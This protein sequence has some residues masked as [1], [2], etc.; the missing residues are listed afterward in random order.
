[1]SDQLLSIA[2]K[3]GGT[4]LIIG[5]LD[6]DG[7][8]LYR[9]PEIVYKEYLTEHVGEN[10]TRSDIYR[11]IFDQT[12]TLLRTHKLSAKNV[13]ANQILRIYISFAGPI[14]HVT[15]LVF[16]PK[17]IPCMKEPFNLKQEMYEFAINHQ[18]F[19]NVK[20]V[21]S[22][23]IHDAIASILGETTEQGTIP[24]INN[25]WTFLSGTGVGAG[26]L[27]DGKPFYG[28]KINHML[29]EIGYFLIREVDRYKYIGYEIHGDLSIPIQYPKSI[30][31]RHRFSTADLLTRYASF[32]LE[33]NAGN[34][35]TSTLT[36]YL[37]LTN[38]VT[39]F[40]K[41]I[42]QILTNRLAATDRL[43]I[44]F[45]QMMSEEFSQALSVF[46]AHPKHQNE[47]FIYHTV[48]GGSLGNL[49]QIYSK[50][51][52]DMIKKSMFVTLQKYGF[53]QPKSKQ[54]SEGIVFSQ[55]G[56]ER[57]LY[58]LGKIL[59]DSKS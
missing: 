47:E 15:N 29:G 7:Q 26:F 39:I 53:S 30:V 44:K 55:I 13:I 9:T 35:D 33:N 49:S 48:I 54:I 37:A 6:Q 3:L 5:L 51:F 38:R 36:K 24:G 27:K 25:A 42:A 52:E 45:L 31:F 57:E 58:G 22:T 23:I 10:Y 34:D 46:F 11:L 1:M 16:R 59:R 50:A 40:N 32:L 56:P 28:E 18:I 2:I 12:N 17:S 41:G 8:L 4:N 21:Q 14:D 19:P 20:T 43:T